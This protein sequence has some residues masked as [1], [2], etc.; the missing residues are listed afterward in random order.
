[1]AEKEVRHDPGVFLAIVDVRRM[2][3]ALD[4]VLLGVTDTAVNRLLAGAAR[5]LPGRHDIF[6][7]AQHKGR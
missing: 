5:M 1:V 4:E 6:V 2:A 3:R 7:A